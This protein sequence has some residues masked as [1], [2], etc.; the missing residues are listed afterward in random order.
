MAEMDERHEKEN[1]FSQ[2]VLAY[3]VPG[4]RSVRKKCEQLCAPP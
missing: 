2:L 3:L 4:Q 1:L